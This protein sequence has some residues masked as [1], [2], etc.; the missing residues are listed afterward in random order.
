MEKRE[1]KRRRKSECEENT[2][3]GSMATEEESILRGEN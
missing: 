3:D 2:D 1:G